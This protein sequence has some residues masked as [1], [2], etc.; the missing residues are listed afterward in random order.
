MLT[1]GT[2]ET[3]RIDNPFPAASSSALLSKGVSVA[4]AALD[5]H[6]KF[7]GTINV[8]EEG[9][10]I[11]M[12]V[13][14]KHYYQPE[15]PGVLIFPKVVPF[16][17]SL[18]LANY[19]YVYGFEIP[20]QSFRDWQAECAKHKFTAGIK[21]VGGV[22]FPAYGAYETIRSG[23][24]VMIKDLE[25]KSGKNSSKK[26]IETLTDIYSKKLLTGIPISSFVL[27]IGEYLERGGYGPCSPQ[28]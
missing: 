12:F 16:N 22:L 13:L 24:E 25:A 3:I 9:P 4:S 21:I 27:E 1:D 14:R 28:A 6:Y 23:F 2:T 11:N 7:L 18:G 10:A 17:D 19:R 26:L 5:V 20:D 15:H 8:C